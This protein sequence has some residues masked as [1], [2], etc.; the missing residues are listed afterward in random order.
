MSAL[1]ASLGTLASL[2]LKRAPGLRGDATIPA[3]SVE[4][5]VSGDPA[6][7]SAY[8][9]SIGAVDDGL[10]PPC[11]P[12][13][14]AV[15]LHLQLLKDPRFPLSALGIVHVENVIEERGSIA[16][17]ATLRVRASVAGH[18]PHDK[19]VT[20]DLVNEAF[21]D[22]DDTA[23]WR[24]VMTVLVRDARL[25]KAQPRSER[26]G[27]LPTARLSSSA[28]RVPEDTGRR[29]AGVSGDAN[30]IHLWALSAKAFGF[31]RAIAHGMWTLARA[32]SEVG[33]AIPQRPRRISVKFIR[34][35]L[36]PSTVL[37]ECVD[38]D[39]ALRIQ[40]SPERG[41]APHLLC[42]VAPL[43]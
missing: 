17:D 39:G 21:V 36:L 3:I 12:Q 2:A 6:W 29:Y 15:G 35:V 27:P 43:V 14:F 20:F 24:S 11:A 41:N 33:D 9:Q 37:T 25:A 32:L 4:R 22:G 7:V 13:V 8:R 16:A 19:G 18:S 23:R 1:T 30:P 42:T 34:P 31:P 10:L 5:V 28:I 40:V 26:E 38:V